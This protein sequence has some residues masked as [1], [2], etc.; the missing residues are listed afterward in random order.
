MRRCW[1]NTYRNTNYPEVGEYRSF[2]N[3]SFNHQKL[4]PSF[5]LSA[6]MN[7][8]DHWVKSRQYLGT[9][10]IFSCTNS[11]KGT[12]AVIARTNKVGFNG[13]QANAF[14]QQGQVGF[15]NLYCS[16]NKSPEN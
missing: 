10:F 13:F 2:F 4:L 12:A 15:G 14:K 11:A 3:C 8:W 7:L 9:I 6:Q 5:S 1:Q 16:R